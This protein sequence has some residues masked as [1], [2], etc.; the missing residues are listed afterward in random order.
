[1]QDP[2]LS[3]H[4]WET[5]WQALEPLME[6]SPGEALPE[7]GDLVERMMVEQGIPIDDEVAGNGVEPEITREFQ[8]ARRITALV[9]RGEDVDPGDIGA[10]VTAYRRLY[11]YLSEELTG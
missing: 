4:E 2:G 11:R 7:L 9:E 8:E 6:D 3:R 1:M 10:A 5:E